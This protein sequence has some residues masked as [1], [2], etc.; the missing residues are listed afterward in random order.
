MRK[1]G[2]TLIELMISIVILSIIMLFLYKSYSSLNKSNKVFSES[3][4]SVGKVQKIK[5]IMFL[6]FSMS[7]SGSIDIQNQDAKNDVV[8]LQTLNSIHDRVNPYVA[9]IFKDKHLFRLESLK[10][11]TGYPLSTDDIFDVDDLGEVSLFRVY[12]SSNKQRKLYLIN[13]EF[14]K[15]EI[16]IKVEALNQK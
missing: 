2:F 1:N 8:F 14:K 10:K 13:A 15:E 7:K 3:I 11:Y 6:D 4:S 16:L 9:Y 5:N 12:K